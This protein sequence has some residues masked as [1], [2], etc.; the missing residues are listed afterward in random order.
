MTAHA[1]AEIVSLHRSDSHSFSKQP[2]AS[3]VFVAG[4][5]LEG[6][7]HSGAMDQHL[8][9]QKTPRP[10]LRQVHVLP[11]ELYEQLN[12]DGYDLSPGG[13][14]ENLVT[15]GISLNDLPVGTTLSLGNDVVIALTG[16]RDPCSQID[17][18]CPGAR[19]AVA[20][21]TEDGKVLFKHGAMAVVLRGGTANVGDA[22]GISLPAGPHHRL[23]KV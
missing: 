19:A 16:L 4:L 10:N 1:P 13:L 15:R 14:G 23:E 9:R 21:T 20:F 2:V 22:I 18:A 5:G 17:K 7:I 12:A 8:S 6:D 11:I 3:A